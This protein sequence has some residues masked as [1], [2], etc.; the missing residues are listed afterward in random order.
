MAGNGSRESVSSGSSGNWRQPEGSGDPAPRVTVGELVDRGVEHWQIV[1]NQAKNYADYV[2][3]NCFCCNSASHNWKDCPEEVCTI[4]YRARKGR[5]SIGHHKSQC[6][7]RGMGEKT[8]SIPGA[9]VLVPRLE[10]RFPDLRSPVV[11]PVSRSPSLEPRS[12]LASGLMRSPS[13]AGSPNRPGSGNGSP[14]SMS[15]GSAR[16]SVSPSWSHYTLPNT[17]FYGSP[18][19]S[20]S[21]SLPLGSPCYVNER[22][23]SYSLPMDSPR[24][25]GAG[26]PSFSLLASPGSFPRYEHEEVPVRR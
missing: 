20:P 26:S 3:G 10:L 19:G 8:G 24:Y 23:P 18:R 5:A 1:E 17:P 16:N 9:L 12:G 22:S 11:A 14:G 15:P 13:Y 25:I 6:M 2:R 7:S 4:C 21:Y